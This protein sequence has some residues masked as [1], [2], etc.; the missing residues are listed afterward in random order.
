ME[1]NKAKEILLKSH[2]Y[3]FAKHTV[4]ASALSKIKFEE[5][6]F[7]TSLAF[8]GETI[9]YSEDY[10]LKNH[11]ENPL[12]PALAVLHCVIHYV[13]LHPFIMPSLEDFNFDNWVLACDIVAE[14]IILELEPYASEK[15]IR[16]A[17]MGIFDDIAERFKTFNAI[18]VYKYI[19]QSNEDPKYLKSLFYKDDHNIWYNHNDNDKN[20]S[21]SQSNSYDEESQS[22]KSD[23]KD[24]DTN[25][26]IPSQE[27]AKESDNKSE[28]DSNLQQ[29][30]TNNKQAAEWKEISQTT[31]VM[32]ESFSNKSGNL[33]LKENISFAN[34]KR[35]RYK[36]FLKKFL[37][38]REEIKI[39]VDE[40][41]YIYYQLGFNL[42]KN[43][44]LI[45]PLEYKDEHQI[46]NIAISIDT[47]GS[48]QG[49]LVKKFLTATYDIIKN[50]GYFKNR[51]CLYIIQCDAK[52][53]DIQFINN[54]KEFD[55]YIKNFE[56]KGGGGTNF[57]PVFEY[58]NNF[59]KNL[60]GLIYFTDGYG[61]YPLKR[62]P[63]KT[64]FVF[65]EEEYKGNDFP[66]WAVKTVFDN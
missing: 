48:T 55:D 6:V 5:S 57:V 16:I 50:S 2:T 42:Y 24:N 40:F 64:A 46:K 56:L 36:D 28:N 29:N 11:A 58:L 3:L 53:Q 41:D 61:T 31:K 37:S 21:K 20:S 19:N 4:F 35:Y 44:P 30:S 22:D 49:E 34:S 9:Y 45:E 54:Q 51:F 32:M 33:I 23:Y 62:P 52:I 60:K 14:K 1:N 18:T 8:D 12:F 7:V 66:K 47:S 26:N 10:I 65:I 39:N 38:L 43:I 25:S 27:N 59:V 63:Y 13:L 15:K 17:Q